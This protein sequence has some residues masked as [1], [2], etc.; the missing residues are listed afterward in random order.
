MKPKDEESLLPQKLLTIS[1]INFGPTDITLDMIN[2]R[3]KLS[4]KKWLNKEAGRF[5]VIDDKLLPSGSRLP[6]T[7][8]VGDKAELLFAT[9]DIMSWALSAK[10]IGIMDTFGRTHWASKRQISLV[11]KRLK[12]D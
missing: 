2:G 9:K 12:K 6:C 7:L 11:S 5:I 3:I 4:L 10:K 8:K 1:V